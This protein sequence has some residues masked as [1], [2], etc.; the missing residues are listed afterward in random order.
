MTT[1]DS[2][3]CDAGGER[4]TCPLHGYEAVI[5]RLQEAIREAVA[6][7]EHDEPDEAVVV[8]YAAC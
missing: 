8:L 3:T 1:P 4:P 7:L 6:Y 5:A 2:C